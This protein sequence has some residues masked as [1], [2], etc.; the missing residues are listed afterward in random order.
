M[1]IPQNELNKMV[2]FARIEQT[3]KNASVK[4]KN[5]TQT[6]VNDC[7]TLL[8]SL[9]VNLTSDA[10][11]VKVIGI[12]KAEI[13]KSLKLKTLSVKCSGI[14]QVFKLVT[15]CYNARIKGTT[16]YKNELCTIDPRKF[17]LF[18]D[19]KV[20]NETVHNFRHHYDLHCITE[21]VTLQKTLNTLIKNA[22][23][24]VEYLKSLI[25]FQ[26]DLATQES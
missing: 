6:V 8:N 14:N 23:N 16:N 26:N 4:A 18:T 9:T 10:D 15:S 11:C 22:D 19:S 12:F 5:K 20:G 21:E 3:G 17:K 2:A 7:M 24:K 25:A 1:T 13:L